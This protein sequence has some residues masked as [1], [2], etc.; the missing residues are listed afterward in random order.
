MILPAIRKQFRLNWWGH[1]GVRHWARVRRNGRIIAQHIEGVDTQVTDLFA[2]L[3]DAGRV[4]EYD[5]PG[6]GWRVMAYL[7]KLHSETRLGLNPEQF[8][9]LLIAIERHS[10]PSATPYNATM[11]ACW[12]A[13]RL[14]IGRVGLTPSKRFMCNEALPPDHII[15]QLAA[16]SQREHGKLRRL[17]A[18][19]LPPRDVS[20]H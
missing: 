4:D 9:T 16:A 18:N 20:L 1:H 19:L 12:N 5:D 8:H 2:V 3:H 15:E 11:A 7:R 10:D 13:D 14:D 6:H 17:H